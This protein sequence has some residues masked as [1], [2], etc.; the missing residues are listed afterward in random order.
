MEKNKTIYYMKGLAIISVVCAHCNSVPNTT[1]R[2]AHVSSL[3]LSNVGTFGVICFFIL[4]GFLFHFKG[5]QIKQFF[6]KKLKYICVPW[7]ISATCVYLYVYMRKPPI[8]VITWINFIIGNGSYC[9]YMT[10]LMILYMIFTIFPFMRSNMACLICEII[11]MVCCI[12]PQQTEISPYLNILNWIGLFALGL[13]ISNNKA[14]FEKIAIHILEKKWR[15][16]LI[17]FILFSAQI[18]SDRSGWYWDG[19]NVI[20]CWGGALTIF[21]IASCLKKSKWIGGILQTIGEY[22]F[23]IYIWH[24]PI[25]GIIANLMSKSKL[26]WMIILRPVIVIAMVLA[27]FLCFRKIIN[28]TQLSKMTYIIGMRF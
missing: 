3:I 1:G 2:F 7:L 21:I 15:F 16:F 4:S 12:V 9:Y 14:F 24:M 19:F 17:Y 26:L 13:H 22:S 10:M 5:G 23:A 20:I 25:A 28:N 11:T 8:Q 18:Y 6:L 27:I